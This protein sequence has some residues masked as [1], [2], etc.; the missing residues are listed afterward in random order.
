M[1]YCSPYDMPCAFKARKY[2]CRM[3]VWSYVSKSAMAY[4]CSSASQSASAYGGRDVPSVCTP[5][6]PHLPCRQRRCYGVMA[7]PQA[8]QSVSAYGMKSAHR[9]VEC[10]SASSRLLW[11]WRCR[12]CRAVRPSTR[13]QARQRVRPSTYPPMSRLARQ[14]RHS[15]AVRPS[16]RPYAPY[17]ASGG[18]RGY[19]QQK[20]Q[21]QKEKGARQHPPPLRSPRSY[22][23][24]RRRSAA[25]A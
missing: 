16:A 10:A 8:R 20:R 17:G 14:F 2:V 7:R 3:S 6:V 15:R 13:P 1:R 18:M 24:I 12:L 9:G 5:C 25:C 19:G 21:G 4:G 23:R 22:V 11:L